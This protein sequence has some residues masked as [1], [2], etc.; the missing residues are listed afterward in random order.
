MDV[1][2]Y[3]LEYDSRALGRL[4]AAALSA[5][6]QDGGPRLG[7][8]QLGQ[9]ESKDD[10]KRRIDQA[11]AYV[12]LRAALPVAAQ[13]GYRQLHGND[14]AVEAQRAKLRLVVEV[15]DDVWGGR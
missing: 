15:A 3:F 10:L 8:D 5:Q 12:P 7:D 11:A 2:A 4:Q 13:C 1:D 14:I 9:L 6:G